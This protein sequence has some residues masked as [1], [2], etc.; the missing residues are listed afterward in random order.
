MESLIFAILDIF[1]QLT[2]ST[3]V[4][5]IRVDVNAQEGYLTPSLTPWGSRS[6]SPYPSPDTNYD[7][8]EMLSNADMEVLQASCGFRPIPCTEKDV[9]NPADSPTEG[10]LPVG[11]VVKGHSLP[12]A[13]SEPL[14]R[15]CLEKDLTAS[16]RHE[17]FKAFVVI[18]SKS[19]KGRDG[20]SSSVK[21]NVPATDPEGQRDLCLGGD[22]EPS[23]GK[24]GDAKEPS[25]GDLDSTKEPSGDK[26]DD[27]KGPSGDK[28]DDEKSEN[29]E[30]GKEGILKGENKFPGGSMEKSKPSSWYIVEGTD[31]DE[32][33]GEQTTSQQKLPTSGDK[34][35][36]VTI[37]GK[38][39][40]LSHR[41]VASS[42]S[43]ITVSSLENETLPGGTV[44]SGAT[45]L[46]RSRSDSDISAHVKQDLNESM[47]SRCLK[48]LNSRKQIF[49]VLYVYLI[50]LAMDLRFT[51]SILHILL[52]NSCMH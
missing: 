12:G 17:A 37:A 51:P 41:R 48:L 7:T 49:Q 34:G 24:M 15:V 52:D 5:A 40:T 27:A 29:V 8:P 36:E 11:G 13:K 19:E 2:K 30:R 22:E 21:E 46:E 43:A 23:G 33:K 35:A 14:A 16:Q 9:N 50:G 3:D 44:T 39:F 26:M 25:G 45:Y 6:P 18:E 1:L 31:G 4:L 10:I 20:C 42:P 47:V 28:M 38:P 32:N